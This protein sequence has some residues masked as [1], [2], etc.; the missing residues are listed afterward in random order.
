MGDRSSAGI[1]RVLS[2]NPESLL[3]AIIPCN[4]HCG[5]KVNEIMIFRAAERS[6]RS[7]FV[8]TGTAHRGMLMPKL[9]DR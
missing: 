5:A 7:L 8:R 6:K 3:A 4:L 9:R 1:R 2:D